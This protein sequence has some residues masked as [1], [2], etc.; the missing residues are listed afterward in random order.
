MKKII[1]I[2][3]ILSGNVFAT[4]YKYIIEN[5]SDKDLAVSYG[6][7]YQ[8]LEI[9]SSFNWEP[10]CSLLK[11]IIVKSKTSNFENPIIQHVADEPQGYVGESSL[12]VEMA[13]IYPNGKTQYFPSTNCGTSQNSWAQVPYG[14]VNLSSVV[15]NPDEI[16]CT[17]GITKK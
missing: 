2:S 16:F 9:D 10:V 14:I 3:L 6:T 4:D 13:Q 11:T 8:A 7:C 5:T 12:I 15:D 17:G 1:L